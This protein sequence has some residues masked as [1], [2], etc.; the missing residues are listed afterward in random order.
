MKDAL[1]DWARLRGYLVAWGP[2]S[3]VDAA[4]GE[5]EARQ[6]RGELDADFARENLGFSM[7]C[8][9]DA[10]SQW[11]VVVVAIPRPGHRVTFTVE[12]RAV[13]A[14]LPPTYV[15]YRAT[16]SDIRE[17]LAACLGSRVEL[18]DAPLKALAARLGVVRYG[19]NNITYAPGMG[20]YLQLVGCVTDAALPVPAGWTPHEPRLL[21][22]CEACGACETVCP[23]GAIDGDRV[24]LHA[25]RCLT[26]AN[27]AAGA[28]PGW[29]PS[30]AHHCLI[31]C[32]LCQRACP[33]NTA[34]DIQD[35][36]VVFTAEET[37]TLLAGAAEPVGPVWDAIREKLGRLG[38]NEDTVIGRNLRAMLRAAGPGPTAAAVGAP[39]D[40]R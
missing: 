6:Q 5:I 23:T 30:S 20:S 16:F 3:A 33:A 31:G 29:L 17:Q 7:Q 8:P 11:R 26:L 4:R 15:R 22:L 13:K 24:L 12:G 28:F 9:P 21:D 19:R 35:A 39:G 34:L 37:S 32:L 10:T 36:G 14:I 25:E 2:V 1:L 18:I 27:E 40:G 38:R